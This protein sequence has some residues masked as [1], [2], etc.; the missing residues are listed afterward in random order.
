MHW[1]FVEAFGRQ[2]KSTF[3]GLAHSLWKFL[4]QGW[5]PWHSSNPSH[6]GDNTGSLTRCA[7][8]EHQN[9]H[10]LLVLMQVFLGPE[11][12]K[13]WNRE[14]I[15]KSVSWVFLILK[16]SLFSA[17]IFIGYPSLHFD[18]FFMKHKS[19]SPI[20]QYI[21]LGFLLVPLVLEILHSQSFADFLFFYFLLL[22]KKVSPFIWKLR[23]LFRVKRGRKFQ[24]W[25][26]RGLTTFPDPHR[27]IL[28]SPSMS[29]D[30]S[31]GLHPIPSDS[32]ATEGGTT[33]P[34]V[35]SFLPTSLQIFKTSL[36]QTLAKRKPLGP[37]AFCNLALEQSKEFQFS[38]LPSDD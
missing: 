34:C 31:L 28:S 1:K 32:G 7:T 29:L 14:S 15:L 21:L 22:F 8:R 16:V 5:N 3:F 19:I 27:M 4:G 17:N 6:C 10:F 30:A 37:E 2:C 20:C 18:Y 23:Q 35:F 38:F 36:S 25:F 33:L 24:I 13:L 12:E 11:L 9:L 26:S